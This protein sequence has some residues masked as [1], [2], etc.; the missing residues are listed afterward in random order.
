MREVVLRRG[1]RRRSG[2]RELRGAESLEHR[3]MLAAHIVGNATSFATIQA[4]V[5]AASPGA[6]INVD[7]GVLDESVTINKSLTLR[8]A[9]AGIDA[10]GNRR[11]GFAGET[12]IRGAQVADGKASSFYVN[13]DNVTIDGFDVQSNTSVNQYGAGIVIAPNHS[14]THVFNNI[15][16]NNIAGLLLANNNAGNPAVIR[17]N[18]F[19]YNNQFGPFSGR[20]IYS[21]GG[22]SGGVLAGVTID[23]NHFLGNHGDYRSTTALE[24]AISFESRSA[25]PQNDIHVTNNT[26]E[27]N[28]K[29]LLAWNTSNLT[30]QGNVATSSLDTGSGTVRFE[31][32]VNNVSITANNFFDNLAPALTIDAKAFA[33][34]SSGVT[35]TNNNVYG[36]G[37]DGNGQGLVLFGSSYQGTL[38]ATNNWWGAASGPGG[39]FG[40]TGDKVNAN[41]S[42]VTVSPFAASPVL[43]RESAFNG[44]PVVPDRQIQ[45]ENY[46]QG[47][48]GVGYATGNVTNKYDQYRATGIVNEWSSDAGGSQDVRS[49]KAGEWLAYT[50][51]VAQGG[52]YRLDFRLA[53]P[54]SPGGTFHA[55][56]DG[57]AAGATMAI[58]NTGGV[59]TWQ[60]VSTANFA[61]A[62][63]RHVITLL[64]DT[65]GS[66]GFGASFNW[67]QLVTISASPAPTVPSA[68]TGLNASAVS[69]S[70][71]NLNW[72]NTATN[73]TGFQIDRSSD[74][75]NFTFLASVGATTFTYSNTGL[76]AGTKYYYRV[77]ATNGAGPS[78]PS[79]IASATTVANPTLATTYLT[80]L[81][82]ASATTDWATVNKDASSN[83]TPIT[84][85]GTTYAKGIGTHAVSQIV[86]NLNGQYQ[87]FVS[88]V[89]VDDEV[90]SRGSVIFQVIGDGKVLFDSGALTGGGTV[91]SVNVSVA[92]V[93]TL[94]LVA[95]N[96][97]PDTIDYDHADWAGAR[98][99]GTPTAP[100]A[101]SGLTA[102]TVSSSQLKLTWTNTAANQTGVRV[103]RS[104]DGTNFN[105]V[106]T[107]AASATTFTDSGLSA[108]TKY[109][110]R[111]VA[112]N[113]VGPSSASNIASATTATVAT[114]TYLSDLSWASATVGYGTIHKDASI[115][116]NPLSLR[117]TTYAKGIGTHANSRIV[118][119]IA[120]KYTT[121]QSDIG[122]DDEVGGLGSVYFQVLGDGV[123][124]YTSPTLTGASAVR[125]VSLNVA[126]VQQLTLIARTTITG[127]IDY[128]HADWADAKLS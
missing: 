69:T 20:G 52:T 64:V 67:L 97:I 123:V 28:G 54:Q 125:R 93:Q 128:D 17:F 114:V 13:A 19:R 18:A 11:Q 80:D 71:I 36:N 117:G 76:A 115:D 7:A 86:Y 10:R 124:L 118:Y 43:N 32:G 33:G 68:P 14:G 4:A 126:G 26:F 51:D 92:G 72:T 127:N 84:L 41:G 44:L 104:T 105:P 53:S 79:N 94:T 22:V 65:N 50:V 108:S 60:T 29:T 48:R 35:F 82:W 90:G 12:L 107:L 103:D 119:N 1:L 91:R 31:G 98:L 63:G 122:I 102:S 2:G 112:I 8:G 3:V 74:G 23:S 100:T 57:A 37:W 62:A 46:D 78:A 5:D 83:G 113:A 39:D 25:T 58:P 49:I 116:G 30:F 89:G 85:R 95:T 87:T 106:T 110:Y 66:Q 59:Q 6:V 75:V 120:G 24:A 101:P 96:G 77:E 109:Y 21:D 56:V 55:T 81:T 73:Q 45:A 99:L 27:E 121:F 38:N 111:V 61:L 70:Q 9:A 34:D 15:I 16:E 88:D 42:S 47:G 40:G